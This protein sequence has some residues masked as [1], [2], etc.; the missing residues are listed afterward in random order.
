KTRTL[1][2]EP[3][4][5]EEIPWWNFDD[6]STGQSEGSNSDTYLKPIAI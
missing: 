4:S 2:H 1:D 3:K 5:P 6:L